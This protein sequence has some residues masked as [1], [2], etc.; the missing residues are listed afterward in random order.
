M[1]DVLVRITRPEGYE[2]VA[3]ELVLDDALRPEWREYAEPAEP[4]EE[5]GE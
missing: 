3:P 5:P 1:S 2:D 4:V